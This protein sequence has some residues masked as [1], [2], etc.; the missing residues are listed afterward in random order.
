[1]KTHCFFT[2]SITKLF[3]A[4]RTVWTRP[5]FAFIAY[6]CPSFVWLDPDLLISQSTRS[7]LQ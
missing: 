1:M 4:L 2:T 7:T 3:F 5:P 6:H